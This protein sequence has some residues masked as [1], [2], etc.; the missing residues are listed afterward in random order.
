MIR[1][2][3]IT[4]ALLLIIS[5]GALAQDQQSEANAAKQ[6]V[7]KGNTLYDRGEYEKARAEYEEAIKLAPNSWEPHYELGQTLGMLKQLPGAEAELKKSVELKADCWL[8][9]TALGNMA[10]DAGTP[11]KALAFY[12]QAIAASASS[13]KPHYNKAITLLRLKRTDDGIQELIT[14]E[15]IERSRSC[16]TLL[17]VTCCGRP[18]TKSSQRFSRLS[19]T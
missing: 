19:K 13:A 2:R 18:S 3:L 12:D 1:L 15:K 4:V 8:C 11:E 5:M 16:R 7:D 10:D 17:T 9:F 14:A 6:H